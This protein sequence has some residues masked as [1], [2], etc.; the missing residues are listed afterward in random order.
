MT[1]NRY[2]CVMHYGSDYRTG[3]ECGPDCK[4]LT[5][6]Q[7][8]SEH[9]SEGDSVTV[10]DPTYGAKTG[11]IISIG[12]AGDLLIEGPMIDDVRCFSWTISAGR[13]AEL[14]R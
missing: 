13:V 11:R 5:E 10:M 3:I 7:Y 14:I 8:V 12:Q 1:T 4:R 6:Y 2:E 9:F